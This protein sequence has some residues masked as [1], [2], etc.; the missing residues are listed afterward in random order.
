M[1]S[2]GDYRGWK[3]TKLH[4]ALITQALITLAYWLMGWPPMLFGE[5][6]MLLLAS[7]SIFSAPAL[8]ENLKRLK[9]PPPPEPPA[10]P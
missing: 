5:Y 3:S 8:M 4:M 7:A 2:R 10:A 9:N 1:A 6:G